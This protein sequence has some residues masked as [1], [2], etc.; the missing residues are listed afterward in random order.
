MVGG[1]G[2]GFGLVLA[3]FRLAGCECSFRCFAVIW[4]S[5]LVGVGFGCGLVNAVMWMF[6]RICLFGLSFWLVSL[7]LLF[8]GLH[9][10][11]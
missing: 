2:C 7:G 5:G 4:F 9:G 10:K 11:F 3:A 8:V 6:G 1:F